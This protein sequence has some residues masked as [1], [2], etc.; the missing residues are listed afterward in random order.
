MIKSLFSLVFLL[1]FVSIHCSYLDLLEKDAAYDNLRPCSVLKE[2]NQLGNSTFFINVCVNQSN[3]NT[4]CN[5]AWINFSSIWMNTSIV[6]LQSNGIYAD[7]SSYI[8]FFDWRGYMQNNG[9]IPMFYASTG[10]CPDI[11]HRVSGTP[12]VKEITL[13]DQSGVKSI[14]NHVWCSD[15]DFNS[16]FP[17]FCSNNTVWGEIP[18]Y[19]C[20]SCNYNG[21]AF[22]VPASVRFAQI[23]FGIPKVMIRSFCSAPDSQGNYI[24]KQAYDPTSVF[25]T[26]ELPALRNNADVT[27]ITIIVVSSQQPN[28]TCDDISGSVWKLQQNITN[29]TTV[30]Q[31]VLKCV[32]DPPCVLK[33]MCDPTE[34]LNPAVMISNNGTKCKYFQTLS[35]S[36][37]LSCDCSTAY[38]DNGNKNSACPG[39]EEF[40][41][42]NSQQSDQDNTTAVMIVGTTLGIAIAVLLVMVAALASLYWRKMRQQSNSQIPM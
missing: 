41:T 16:T 3:T 13:E 19:N 18:N 35:D 31:W 33:I 17:G 38:F 6:G 34:Q 14:A 1:L 26:E 4:T 40:A 25:A 12:G 15:T 22:W 10:Q 5:Q 11:V 27:G 2:S 32:V 7:Y 29:S 37:K 39:V 30:T 42:N 21:A 28:E 36:E 8:A 20:S 24:C 23:S 9:R